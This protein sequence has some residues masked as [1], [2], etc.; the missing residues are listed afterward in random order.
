MG[1]GS[2]GC[3]ADGSWRLNPW[4]FP[5]WLTGP[6]WDLPYWPVQWG[7][8]VGASL[9]AAGWDVRTGRIPNWLTA[10]LWIGGLI[11]CGVA[12]GFGALGESLAASILVALPYVI[13]FVLGAGGA[14]DAKMM[15]AVGAW[16]GVAGGLLVIPAVAACGWALGVVI[17][18]RHRVVRRLMVQT[19]LSVWEL[20]SVAMGS[21]RLSEVAAPASSSRGEASL[22]YG[23]A[24]SIGVCLAAIWRVVWVA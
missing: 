22:R 17:A 3:T 7:V 21:G 15:G 12:G 20:V 10:S 2:L 1:Q 6:V 24:I 8:V 11:F 5:D 14:G 4:T 18:I 16:V 23:V 13:L 9:V 19:Q